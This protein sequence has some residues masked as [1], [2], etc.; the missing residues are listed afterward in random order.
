MAVRVVA[1]VMLFV[2]TGAIGAVARRLAGASEPAR[3]KRSGVFLGLAHTAAMAS[4]AIFPLLG[5]GD[6][7]IGPWAWVAVA[8][9]LAAFAFQLW[10]MFTLG[11]LFTL[12]LQAAA[13]Q[14]LVAHGPYRVVRHPGYLAQILFFVAFAVAC[15]NVVT[16]IVVVLADAA[17]YAYRI[18]VE[19][20]FLREALGARYAAYAARRARLVPCIW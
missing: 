17:A 7:S 4:G 9:M 1:F 5:I 11:P 2:V 6:V 12:T 14:D 3:E 15:Q 20:R 10:A 16:V 19:E 18:R 13:E 8:G